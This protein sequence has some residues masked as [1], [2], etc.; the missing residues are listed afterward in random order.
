MQPLDVQV[1]TIACQVG[2]HVQHVCCVQARGGDRLSED[3]FEALMDHFEKAL[4][5][6]LQQRTELWPSL[7]GAGANLP[8]DV[9][10]ALPLEQ[11]LQGQARSG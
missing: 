7:V 1:W 2:A 11:A 8:P 5:A 9:A 4:Q 6:A 3:A 10:D